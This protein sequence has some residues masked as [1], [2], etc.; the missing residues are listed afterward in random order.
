[1]EICEEF[2]WLEFVEFGGVMKVGRLGFNGVFGEIFR[3][4]KVGVMEV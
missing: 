2:L 4:W 3:G 1:M